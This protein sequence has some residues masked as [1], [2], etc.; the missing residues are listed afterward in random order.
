MKVYPD[1]YCSSG[2]IISN[3][4]YAILPSNLLQEH[5]DK[6]TEERQMIFKVIYENLEIGLNSEVYVT[7][8][9]FT[10]PED[11][12]YLNYSIFD[13][14]MCNI[15]DEVSIEYLNLHLQV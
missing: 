9:E 5:S 4:N 8:K 1:S 11:T 7:A 3:S 2:T 14:L 13:K 10:A 15:G 6:I 12:I